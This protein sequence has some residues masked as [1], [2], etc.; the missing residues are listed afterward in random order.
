MNKFIGNAFEPDG[1]HPLGGCTVNVCASDYAGSCGVNL[2]R[3]NDMP[4][5][6]HSCGVDTKAVEGV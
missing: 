4:C 1:Y 2:C 3:V 5:R 6:W